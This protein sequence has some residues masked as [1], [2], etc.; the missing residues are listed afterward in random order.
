MPVTAYRRC[1]D[2]EK[3][4]RVMRNGFFVENPYETRVFFTSKPFS[5]LFP[6]TERLRNGTNSVLNCL[7]QSRQNADKNPGTSKNGASLPSRYIG[8]PTP[9]EGNNTSLTR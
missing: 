2:F 7:W 5:R 3:T 6:T 4:F 1:R 8:T 9:S